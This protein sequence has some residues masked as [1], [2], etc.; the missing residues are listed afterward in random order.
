MGL[1][2][3][4]ATLI[5]GF[6]AAYVASDDVRY[7][8]RAGFEE[9]RI[10]GNRVPIHRLA[11]DSAVPPALREEAK[12]VLA[13]R[14]YAAVLGLEAKETFTMYSDVGRDTLAPG[15]DRVAA[16]TASVR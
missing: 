3:A 2:I 8:S 6:G 11:A 10:L 13:A 7:L 5:L 1:L 14:A 12:L 16:R 4:A 15:A 9:M